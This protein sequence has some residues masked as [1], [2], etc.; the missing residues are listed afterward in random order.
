MQARLAEMEAEKNAVSAASRGQLNAGIGQADA[1][2]EK[3]AT[4]KTEG[5]EG[6]EAMDDDEAPAAVDSRSIYVGNVSVSLRLIASAGVR[7]QRECEDSGSARAVG[8]RGTSRS[9]RTLQTSPQLQRRSPRFRK[10]LRFLVAR[11]LDGRPGGL[12]STVALTEPSRMD[13]R[14][15]GGA[16]DTRLLSLSRGG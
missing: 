15:R 9:S 8:V 4:P 14:A 11:D 13:R 3:E 1:Q 12:G 5:G 10:P 7:G 16:W 2:L 6:D